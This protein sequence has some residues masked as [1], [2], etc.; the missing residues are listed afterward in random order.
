MSEQGD[1]GSQGIRLYLGNCLDVM[2][3]IAEQSVD[4][5]LADP[6]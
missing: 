2:P 1:L 4:M 3:T 6:P 5:I